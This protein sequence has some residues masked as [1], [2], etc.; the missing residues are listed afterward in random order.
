MTQLRDPF[1]VKLESRSVNPQDVAIFDKGAQ[2][3]HSD[4]VF[5]LVRELSGGISSVVR[6]SFCRVTVL[7]SA[8]VLKGL[9]K[10]PV[11]EGTEG[12]NAGFEQCVDH[13]IIK[14]QALRI[15]LA[16]PT[17]K[18]SRPRDREPESF[19]S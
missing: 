14:I 10:I 19:E 15:G 17:R 18:D 4:E 16:R 1:G 7:P 12:L 13:M 6:E 5:H 11:I 8:L 3:I 2:L 9:R